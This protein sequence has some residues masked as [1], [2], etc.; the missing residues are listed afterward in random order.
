MIPARARVLVALSGGPD[1]TALLI[2]LQALGCPL[3]A[4]HFDHSLRPE[5]PAEAI[6]VRDLCQRLHIPLICGV[7]T[8]PLGEGSVQAGARSAR[9]AFLAWAR[10]E[11]QSD[12]VALA[13]TADDVVEGVGLHLS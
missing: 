10:G 3:V 12:V 4:A 5:S 7:R 2:A 1:S 6:W 8:E 9:Y 13:H 11:S